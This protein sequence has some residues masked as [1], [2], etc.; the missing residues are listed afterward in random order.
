MKVKFGF[1]LIELLVVIA[2][3]G[4]LSSLFV[5]NYMEI[6]KKSRD[7]KRM[8][9]LKQIQ[10]ALELYKQDQNPPAYPT[11]LPAPC[12]EWRVGN[13]IYMNSVPG[14][15]LG[16]CNTPSPY[17]YSRTDTLKYT[18]EA[19]METLN[20]GENIKACSGLNCSNFGNNN[21]CFSVYEP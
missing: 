7:A 21:L 10:K 13:K 17:Y 18:L 12:S 5:S 11:A 8:S 9:D 19:C 16:N 1:T 2:I 6:R 14:D 3:I 4:M 20:S 15:P